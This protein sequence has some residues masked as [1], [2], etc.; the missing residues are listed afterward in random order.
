MYSAGRR[1]TI[2]L[3]ECDNKV[4]MKPLMKN[5]DD[6]LQSEMPRVNPDFKVCF[7]RNIE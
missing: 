3:E 5:D 1:F 2:P 4:E 6:Y 7:Y